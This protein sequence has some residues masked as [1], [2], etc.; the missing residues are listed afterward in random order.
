MPAF[1]HGESRKSRKEYQAWFHMLDRCRNPKHPQYCNYGARGI[2]VCD[3]WKNSFS[4]FLS[5]MGKC[6]QG[7]SLGRIKNEL[8]YFKSNCRWED[9]HQQ[10]RNKRNNHRLTVNGKTETLTYWSEISGIGVTTIR[11]R[12]NRGWPTAM[13]IYLSRSPIKFVN[14]CDVTVLV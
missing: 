8:G 9:C 4:V 2:S 3:E 14:R 13:A 11:A 7:K 12:L 10:Q 5:D 6:P 1:I